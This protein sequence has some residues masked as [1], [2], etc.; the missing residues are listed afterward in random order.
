MPNENEVLVP[1]SILNWLNHIPVDQGVQAS[2]G[3]TPNNNITDDLSDFSMNDTES[4]GTDIS[5]LCSRV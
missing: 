5:L 4:T 3:S 1:A 2:D